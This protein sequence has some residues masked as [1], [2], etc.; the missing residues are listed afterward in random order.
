MNFESKLLLEKYGKHTWKSHLWVQSKQT[1]ELQMQ[2]NM[3]PV[4]K[5]EQKVARE[6][7]WQDLIVR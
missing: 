2:T 6:S 3:K 7:K 1:E 4:P 5:H